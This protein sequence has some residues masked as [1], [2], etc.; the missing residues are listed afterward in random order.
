LTSVVEAII[1]KESHN[2]ISFELIIHFLF[3]CPAIIGVYPGKFI[4]GKTITSDISEPAQL[5]LKVM[6]EQP[7]I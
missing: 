7:V 5:K 1:Y 6:F 4:L 2:L 3:A